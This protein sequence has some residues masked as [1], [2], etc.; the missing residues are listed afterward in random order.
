[1]SFNLNVDSKYMKAKAYSLFLSSITLLLLLGACDIMP[2][3]GEMIWDINFIEPRIYLEDTDGNDLLAAMPVEEIAKIRVEAQ[4]K[5]FGVYTK[6]EFEAM[7][8]SQREW[9]PKQLRSLGPPSFYGALLEQESESPQGGT[10][11]YYIRVGQYSGEQDYKGEQ[12]S[13]TWPDGSTNTIT[14]DYTVKTHCNKLDIRKTFYLDGK[15]LKRGNGR[16]I[17][18]RKPVK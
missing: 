6:E 9:V 12:I 17:V 8:K 16:L 4:G 10:P 13:I 5:T 2:K 14:F 11:H 3:C 15:L 18:I 7:V 1:M